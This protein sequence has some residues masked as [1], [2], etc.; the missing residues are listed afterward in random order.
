MAHYYD[1]WL[2][3]TVPHY[4]GLSPEQMIQKREAEA[5]KL[6]FNDLALEVTYHHLSHILLV[7]LTNPATT[8]EEIATVVT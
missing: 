7:I 1:C 8:W 2:E 3:T 4:V 5:N 6:F